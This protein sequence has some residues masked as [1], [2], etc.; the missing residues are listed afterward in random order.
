ME[1]AE[2]IVVKIRVKNGKIN[3]WGKYMCCERE[4]K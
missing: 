1:A 2:E 3:E 4:D